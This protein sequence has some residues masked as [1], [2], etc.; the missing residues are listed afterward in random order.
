MELQN[1]PEVVN[2]MTTL[3]IG[4]IGLVLL[5]AAVLSIVLGRLNKAPSDMILNDDQL[6]F[7][8]S[9]DAK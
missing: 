3:I 5:P 6:K 2:I 9:S 7:T 4:F 1:Q 8:I